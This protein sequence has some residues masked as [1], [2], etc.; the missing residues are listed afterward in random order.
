MAALR[1]LQVERGCWPWYRQHKESHWSRERQ[2]KER[3]RSQEWRSYES[4][5]DV[6]TQEESEM[7]RMNG[8]ESEIWKNA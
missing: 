5:R 7:G 1:Q 6:V 8:L 2:R 4:G 3:Q